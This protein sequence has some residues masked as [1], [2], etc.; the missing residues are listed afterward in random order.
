MPAPT[1]PAAT[2][3]AAAAAVAPDAVA[4]AAAAAAA[5]PPLHRPDTALR[6][7]AYTD[8]AYRVEGVVIEPFEVRVRVRGRD[9]G[10]VRTS[11]SS[12]S[13]PGA[14]TLTLPLTLIL[15]PTRQHR[16]AAGGLDVPRLR[17]HGK[18]VPTL[19]LTLISG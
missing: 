17:R 19:V 7:P 4:A 16:D 2:A 10:R 8:Y 12:P 15:T 6:V 1:S 18:S 9:R 13:R 5:A 3:F 14:A 11:S